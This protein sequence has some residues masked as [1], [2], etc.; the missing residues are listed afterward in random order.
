M[1]GDLAKQLDAFAVEP[2]GFLGLS[3][4]H[5][6]MCIGYTEVTL[7]IATMLP[8]WGWAVQVESS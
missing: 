2:W 1:H 5:F 3:G 6:R 4:E 8:W 7:A